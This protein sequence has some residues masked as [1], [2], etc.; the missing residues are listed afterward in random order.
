MKKCAVLSFSDRGKILSE[1]IAK[2][3]T[4]DFEVSCLQP[5]GVLTERTGELFESCDA[6]VFVGACGIAVRA[7]VPY[8]VSKTSDPAVLVIDERGQH[9][10]SLLS[11]HIGGAN[12]LTWRIAEAIG[13]DPVITTATD[14]NNRFSVDAWAAKNGLLIGEMD[15]AKKFSAEILKRDLPFYSELPVDGA[16][17]EGIVLS[18]DGDLGAAV[19]FRTTGPYQ[20]TLRLIPKCLHLGIGCRRGTPVQ[21]IRSLTE[22][23]LAEYGIDL[24]AVRQIAS[25]D[26][27]SDEE[28]LL[29]FVEAI[30]VPVQFYSAEQLRQIQG[31]FTPSA[32]VQSQ[33]GVDNVCERAAMCSAGEGAKLIVK[34]TAADGVTVAVAQENRR[35]TFE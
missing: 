25:I 5:R 31:D 9:V 32:F 26:V 4:D 33:V 7:I 27:K 21:R 6:I 35:L 13:A 1:K 24:R 20:D 17:P 29:T 34:K 28:G 18:Q 14:V 12:G 23:T 22:D 3:L 10:I 19:T 2:V 16:L 15:L 30:D 11:G 8:V